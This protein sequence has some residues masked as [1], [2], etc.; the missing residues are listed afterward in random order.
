M[1]FVAVVAWWCVRFSDCWTRTWVPTATQWF[2]VCWNDFEGLTTCVE[3]SPCTQCL[4]RPW[5]RS[6]GQWWNSNDDDPWAATGTTTSPSCDTRAQFISISSISSIYCINNVLTSSI[7][8]DPQKARHSRYRIITQCWQTCSEAR[9]LR[10][11]QY[12]RS[13]RL[14]TVCINYSMY[15]VMCEVIKYCASSRAMG[16]ISVYD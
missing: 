2:V 13:K 7:Y 14:L 3:C 5:K 9:F 16:K 1:K 12:G 11:I 6:A 10:Q 4:A 8:A 15:E